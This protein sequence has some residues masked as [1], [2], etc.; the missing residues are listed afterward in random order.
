[1]FFNRNITQKL[2]A[3]LSR[4]PVVLLTGARQT[5]KTTLIKHLFVQ[6]GYTYVTFDDVRYLSAAKNDPI[7][8]LKDLPKPTVLDE[9]QR[10]PELFLSIKHY[11]DENRVPG[12]FILTGS[13]NPLLI[14]N[15]GDSL[16][17]R[18]EIVELFPLSQGEIAHKKENFI[19]N[20]FAANIQGLSVGDGSREELAKK[21]VTGGFPQVQTYDSDGREAWF[22]A[23]LTT[24]LQ[25]DVKDLARIEG[26]TLLPNL[27]EL[28]AT[29]VGSLLNVAE[30]A[31]TSGISTSTLH[32]YL[33][34]LETLYLITLQAPWS[35]HL[36]K[37]LVKAPKIYL[38]DAG[39]QL[40]LL[41]AD[42]QRILTDTNML[43][44]VVENFIITEILKQISW[45]DVRVR[46]YHYRTD[47]GVEV[48]IILENA[49]GNVVGIEIKS[50]GTIISDDFKGLRSVQQ[51]CGDKFVAGIVLY[52]GVD[53][54]PFGNNLWAVP[55][56]TL[57]S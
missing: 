17:G 39:I 11:V 42:K 34:L 4:S 55:I 29:R 38:V 51:D 46:L 2:Q 6:K 36:G 23:Y 48:D 22:N 33:T 19:Q 44:K 37:R 31:R 57:W 45:A 24:I 9:V 47:S 52:S 30:L 15:L 5:G 7:G 54:I 50:G 16:A 18:M 28:I 32:R 43:G 35:T 10:V 14:P 13:A 49:S 20:I 40:H 27:L 3:A 1:M 41:S 26:L 56:S 12:L 25:R 8:F 53:K 21:L